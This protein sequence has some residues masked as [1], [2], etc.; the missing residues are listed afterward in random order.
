MYVKEHVVGIA[1]QDF[2]GFTCICAYLHVGAHSM[3]I[4]SKTLVIEWCFYLLQGA[5][6]KLKEKSSQTLIDAR[7]ELETVRSETRAKAKGKQTISI[8]V[9]NSG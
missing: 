1:I 6:S 5:L 9:L 4:S 8:V 7:N 3:A 2:T